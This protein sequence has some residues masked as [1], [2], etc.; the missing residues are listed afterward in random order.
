[1]ELRCGLVAR[2]LVVA[3][4]VA[5]R[6]DGGGD[7]AGQVGGRDGAGGQVGVDDPVAPGGRGRRLDWPNGKVC[8]RR[9]DWGGDA[10]RRE[11]GA[12]GVDAARVGG[13]VEVLEEG[14]LWFGC[15][16]SG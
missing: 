13:L 7:V 5:H 14:E 1:M 9:G 15:Y 16:C 12:A 4:K 8:R 3:A 6:G 11:R 2:V 10:R